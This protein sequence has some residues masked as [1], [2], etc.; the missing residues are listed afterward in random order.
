MSSAPRQTATGDTFVP[1]NYI[2]GQ[3]P[4]TYPA[5]F[6]QQQIT[7]Q[8]WT[9]FITQLNAVTMPLAAQQRQNTLNQVNQVANPTLNVNKAMNRQ[10]QFQ[11]QQ[12][13]IQQTFI[14]A[15]DQVLLQ[16]NQQ[17]F[18]PMGMQAT[19]SYPITQQHNVNHY[20]GIG[21]AAAQQ[22][23]VIIKR[24]QV[25]QQPQVVYVVQQQPNNVAP[26]QQQVI[27]AGPNNAVAPPSYHSVEAVPPQ[28]TNQ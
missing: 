6:N 11:S 20:G 23:G 3:Y 16:Y 10:A 5:W 9:N 13:Q 26:Q 4:Q 1:M 28:Y 21:G 25:Q 27:V 14:T 17:L 12:M 24:I 2:N 15:T 8:T 19:S 18:Q 7:V 22:I